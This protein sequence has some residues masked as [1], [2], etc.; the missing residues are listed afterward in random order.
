MEEGR[1]ELVW[2]ER[3]E[4]VI[5]AVVHGRVTPV[6]QEGTWNEDGGWACLQ[7]RRTVLL[8]SHR[9]TDR[10]QEVGVRQEERPKK[11]ESEKTT[12]CAKV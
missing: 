9:D 3:S 10:R 11:T 2:V 6:L 7:L 12:W 5:E 1:T 8:C 4:G